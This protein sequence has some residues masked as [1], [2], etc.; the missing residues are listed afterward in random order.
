MPE[1][2]T[3]VLSGF[4]INQGDHGELLVTSFFTWACD[5]VVQHSP[6]PV[7]PGQLCHFFLVESLFSQLFSESV[8]KSMLKDQPT[9][10]HS[11]AT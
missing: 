10:Y 1:A 11:K 4:C 7:A 5:Q 8:F 6:R 2:L 9:H 3:Q